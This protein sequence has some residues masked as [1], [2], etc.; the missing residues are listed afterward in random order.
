[1]RRRI[2]KLEH[3]NRMHA[4]GKSR[5]R[6]RKKTRAWRGKQKKLDRS[7]RERGRRQKRKEV[8][9]LMEKKREG[10]TAFE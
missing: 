3:R 9:R 6:A 4:R 1:M 7:G 5:E 8:A 2:K 10:W